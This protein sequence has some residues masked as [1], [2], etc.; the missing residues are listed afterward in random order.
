MN[1]MGINK[2]E[3]RRNGTTAADDDRESRILSVL[4]EK[5]PDFDDLSSETGIPG[6]VLNKIIV[7]MMLKNLIFEKGGVYYVL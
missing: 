7:E 4:K 5:S 6:P 1:E 3:T 2:E